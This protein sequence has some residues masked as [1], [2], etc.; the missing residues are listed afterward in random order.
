M[1]IFTPTLE[2]HLHKDACLRLADAAGT[3]LKS[4]CGTLWITQCGDGTD[5]IIEPGHAFVLDRNGLSLVCSMTDAVLRLDPPLRK[6]RREI[7]VA[8]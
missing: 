3:T 6:L 7:D 2:L 8:A 1:R 5:H 4:R